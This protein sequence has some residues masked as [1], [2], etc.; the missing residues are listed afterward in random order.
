MLRQLFLMPL[1]LLAVSACDSDTVG[2]CERAS[3]HILACTGGAGVALESG[4]NEAAAGDVLDMDC[5]AISATVEG[6]KADGGWASANDFMCKSLGFGSYCP[7]I[8]LALGHEHA[9][10]RRSNGS[11]ACWGMNLYGQLSGRSPRDRESAT[12]VSDLDDVA[13][14]ALGVFHTCARHHDR[15]VSCLGLN[16]A[17]EIGVRGYGEVREPV[18]VDGLSRVV[19]LVAGNGSNCAL[20][21]SGEVSCWGSNVFG[22]LGNGKVD[23]SDHATPTRVEGLKGVIQLSNGWGHVC[24]LLGDAT[25]SC[26]GSNYD[27]QLGHEIDDESVHPQPGP[28]E[29][30]TG[31]TQLATGDSHSCALHDDGR[32]SCWGGNERGQLG[33]ELTQSR[34]TKP[35]EVAGIRNAVELV[36][37]KLHTCV[38]NEDDSVS[39]WGDNRFGQL[40]TG[41]TGSEPVI[42][43]VT[44]GKLSRPTKLSAGTDFTCALV[45]AGGAMCWGKGGSGQLGNDAK[46]N[47]ASPVTVVDLL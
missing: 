31:V 28:V 5:P 24:A 15:T 41:S 18:V 2:V 37:G 33:L 19:Q 43:P 40:G 9:C 25:V 22:E 21:D 3:D 26:W 7:A 44:V 1:M 39:C 27:G 32:V 46:R 17:G 23:N 20:H 10:A 11:V 6:G 29:G 8:D 38:R 34:I 42:S 14:M 47:S 45:A 4:C 13:E 36:V 35:V 16:Q 12:S 30:L